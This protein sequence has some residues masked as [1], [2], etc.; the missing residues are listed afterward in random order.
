MWAEALV[1]PNLLL[2]KDKSRNMLENEA[3]F[4]VHK[5]IKEPS[6]LWGSMEV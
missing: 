1:G 4:E 3:S 2:L 5:F 6:Q